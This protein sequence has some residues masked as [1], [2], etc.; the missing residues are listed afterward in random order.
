MTERLPYVPRTSRT[1][2][3]SHKPA[4]PEPVRIIPVEDSECIDLGPR[5]D[6]GTQPVSTYVSQSL[7][8]DFFEAEGEFECCGPPREDEGIQDAHQ[9]ISA[10]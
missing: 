2:L 4:V 3:H 6:S 1:E 10:L 7:P 5:F 9:G 8:V